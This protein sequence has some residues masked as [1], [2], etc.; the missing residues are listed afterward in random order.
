MLR[1]CAIAFAIVAKLSSVSTISAAFFATSVPAIPI[2]IPT[3]ADF[4]DGASF[5][6]SPV[7]AAISP[8]FLHAATMRTLC[9]GDT[10]A[11]TLVPAIR[12]A[13]S[14]SSIPSSS[15]P[16]I[17][18]EGSCAIPISRAMANAVSTRSPVIM[19][20]FTPA[21][22]NSATAGATSGRTGSAI[23]ANPK[24]VSPF[25]SSPMASSRNPRA[26]TRS[27]FPVSSKSAFCICFFCPG[28]TGCR[29]PSSTVYLH[30]SK[31]SSGDPFV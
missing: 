3:S 5:T 18:W 25:S 15:S 11:N 4:N 22:A 27:P 29:C 23:P 1:P 6:P 8:F 24:K 31:I 10:C 17:H 9:S 7:I 19:I 30:R 12:R 2:A 20:V 28:V 26:R 14:A 13:S 21:L 16:C